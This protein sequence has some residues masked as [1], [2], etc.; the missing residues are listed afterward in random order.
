MIKL[1]LENINCHTESVF[2]IEQNKLTLIKGY[3]GVGKSSIFQ[4]IT[5]CLYG[6]IK[7][8]CNFNATKYSVTLIM[9]NF[10]IYRMGK[11]KLLRLT[12]ANGDKYEDEVAQNMI[13]QY[14]GTEDIWNITCYLEQDT[15]SL[16]LNGSNNDRMD[17]LNK[18]SFW[19]DNP[20][21]YLEKIDNEIRIQQ[22]LFKQDQISYKIECD[23]FSLELSKNKLSSSD[24]LSPE[25]KIN[26]SN[27][28]IDIG[29][30]NK[31]LNFQLDEQNKIIGALDILDITLKKNL[32]DL[33][34]YN[35]IDQY[36]VSLESINSELVTKNAKLNDLMN[37][38]T[39]SISSER[40]EIE[41]KLNEI[42]KLVQQRNLYSNNLNDNTHHYNLLNN[43]YN[44]LCS[45]LE[46]LKGLLQPEELNHINSGYTRSHLY[47]IME[48]EKLYNQG[49]IICQQIGVGYDNISISNKI[50][51][52]IELQNQIKNYLSN[53]DIMTKINENKSNINLLGNISVV[54]DNEIL[55]LE[56]KLRSM[57]LSQGVLKCPH[58]SR[59][60]RYINGTLK[61]EDGEVYSNVDINTI[62]DKIETLKRGKDIYNK[63]MIYT[64]Q[65]ESM[66]S[67]LKTPY[68]DLSNEVKNLP[69]YNSIINQLNNIKI[70]SPV[71]SF[72][73]SSNTLSKILDYTDHLNIV[74]KFDMNRMSY[75][76]K[77]IE[78]YTQLL[79]EIPKDID[80]LL[81][82]NNEKIKQIDNNLYNIRLQRDNEVGVIK[83]EINKLLK[84]SDIIKQSINNIERL[85]SQNSDLTGQIESLRIQVIPNINDSIVN[86]NNKLLE[87][88]RV[89]ERSNY[90]DQ[91]STK[92]SKINNMFTLLMDKNKS[93]SD[94]YAL[95]Q[96]AF[97]LECVQLQNI[98]DIIN[99][100]MNDI[101]TDIFEKPIK[102]LLNLYK[103][104][105]S[106]DRIK[107][108]VNLTI[109]YDGNEY[110][111]LK[112]LSGGEKDRISFALTLALCKINS[113]NLL[114]LDEVFKSLNDEF[115]TLCIDS[116]R[117]N[118][119]GG[120]TILCISH[121][122]IEGNYDNVISL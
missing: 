42:S 95:K 32:S 27:Q 16:L 54:D 37:K 33:S 53:A 77:Q 12:Y 88:N 106:N 64:K 50:K 36:V 80:S 45:R 89:I 56:N 94:L 2:S 59:G 47:N 31:K 116:M 92:Q 5:W 51:E 71:G 38:D 18:L 113:S 93:L 39:L 15:R 65:I 35:S 100:T 17:L 25:D 49:I 112:N 43:E 70:V 46:I 21:Y 23:N 78:T 52:L 96:T 4:G 83:I 7:K 98:V 19:S 115:R 85:T 48:Q 122:D 26:I 14:F 62:K 109:Q 66:T 24:Y 101:L 68:I 6:K 82:E 81:V 22:D 84:D 8:L 58:C 41:S 44:A 105:K 119:N 91:M 110:D 87:L 76:K 75:H 97:D 20:D 29:V 114:L 111:N 34:K 28:I 90:Y 102:V 108:N 72:G 103:K 121:E 86:N 63:Y 10:T 55:S 60:I 74:N 99:D 3:S 57:I 107:P 30:Q 104:N 61:S 118:L 67:L 13:N 79:S 11:P 1:I 117:K 40:K 120:K 69:M 73:I 9:D